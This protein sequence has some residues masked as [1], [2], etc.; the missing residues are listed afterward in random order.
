ERMVRRTRAAHERLAAH[1]QRLY[2]PRAL[3]LLE[4]RAAHYTARVRMRQPGVRR[5][6]IVLQEL[7]RGRYRRFGYG[8]KGAMQDLLLP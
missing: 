1:R 3:S 6:P 7:L 2:E 4:A 8:W 5:W